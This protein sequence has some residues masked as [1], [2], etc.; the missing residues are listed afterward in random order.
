MEVLPI[1]KQSV[2]TCFQSILLLDTYL[3]A[4]KS[5]LSVSNL[6]L[7]GVVAM[8][9]A[10]KLLELKPLTMHQVLNDISKQKFSKDEFVRSEKHILKTLKF[11]LSQPS[12]YQFSSYL[13]QLAQLP[14]SLRDSV[15]QYANF[16]QKMFLYSYDLL[17]VFSSLELA[18]YSAVIS[19][20]FLQLSYPK[21]L[22]QNHFSRLIKLSGVPK[23]R[24][25]E[26]L[27]FLR[28][29]ASNFKTAFPFNR[30]HSAKTHKFQSNNI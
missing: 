24:I 28:D 20:K 21:L 26:N 27:T 14:D 2:A 12:I 6:H 17:N 7:V 1:F 23:S 9:L 5:P 13:F 8:F 18:L 16:L 11:Q 10:S 4:E 29:F 25:L 22:G 15:E 30:L 3:K 19:T